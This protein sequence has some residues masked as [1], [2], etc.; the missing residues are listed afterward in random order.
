MRD[1]ESVIL[2][3]FE[4]H[5]PETVVTH[6]EPG[7]VC[8][9]VRK[10]AKEHGYPLKT[11]HL[12]HW[13]MQ[14]QFHH[15]SLAVLEDSEYAVFIHDGESRGTSNELSLAQKL[16]TPYTYYK[17]VDGKLVDMS[18]NEPAGGESPLEMVEFEPIQI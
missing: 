1:A 5:L 10:L 7:G 9:H 2:A 3:E 18:D 16:K 4:K 8:E 15:R 13:R 14:G 6:G 17:L 11:Y 12:Q